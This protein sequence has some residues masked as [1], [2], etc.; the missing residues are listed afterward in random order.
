M[1]LILRS[2]KA[3]LL[4]KTACTAKKALTVNSSQI[5]HGLVVQNR[6]NPET[7]SSKIFQALT[8]TQGPP[9]SPEKARPGSVPVRI[10]Q[11]PTQIPSDPAGSGSAPQRQTSGRHQSKRILIY[12]LFLQRLFRTFSLPFPD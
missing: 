3:G 8:A 4:A 10:Q 9:S 12:L 5:T 11:H 6:K 7:H 1:K 2:A